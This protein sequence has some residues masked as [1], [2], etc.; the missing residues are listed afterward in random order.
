MELRIRLHLPELIQ[1]MQERV[2]GA[3]AEPR[4]AARGLSLDGTVDFSDAQRGEVV[5]V[6]PFRRAIRLDSRVRTVPPPK[7]NIV[8]PIIRAKEWQR[9]LDEKEVP[10]RFALAKSVFTL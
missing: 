5:I 2:A 10:H 6:S 4:V 7:P 3:R 9:M 1:G 8:H